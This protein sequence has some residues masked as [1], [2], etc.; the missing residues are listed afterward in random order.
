[1]EGYTVRCSRLGDERVG[2]GLAE[3]GSALGC[4]AYGQLDA[5]TASTSPQACQRNMHGTDGAEHEP[6][7]AM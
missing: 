3:L 4:R 5:L 2:F 1:M 7:G 6:D